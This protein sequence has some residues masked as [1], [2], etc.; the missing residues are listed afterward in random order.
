MAV[1][2]RMSIEDQW[3]HSTIPRH[4]CRWVEKHVLNLMDM[5]KYKGASL[6]GSKLLERLYETAPVRY[7]SICGLTQRM[8]Y[9]LCALDKV[10]QAEQ[11]LCKLLEMP[12]P[13][14]DSEDLCKIYLAKTI[15]DLAVGLLRHGRVVE[16][17]ALHRYNIHTTRG[18]NTNAV[19][20]LDPY[21]PLCD[22]RQLVSCLLL[23]GKHN[24]AREVFDEHFPESNSTVD[25]E[26]AYFRRYKDLCKLLP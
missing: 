19:D 21:N 26:I 12:K 2:Q 10:S 4:S 11:A 7:A 6:L 22:Y 17:E 13:T 8:V 14:D 18:T 15:F 23:Q 9:C 24:E 1:W 25:D 3:G 5:K 16:A 20:G